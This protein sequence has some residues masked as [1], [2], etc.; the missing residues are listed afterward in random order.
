MTGPVRRFDAAELRGSDALPVSEAE[1]AAALGVARGLERAAADDIRPTF[2]FADRVMAAVTTEPAP[3]VIVRPADT[4]LGGR[5]GAFLV[6]V[7]DAWR[8]SISP[9][10]PTFVRAQAMA[11]VFLVVLAS[12]SLS[13]VAAIGA[14][15]FLSEDHDST[16]APTAPIGPSPQPMP[17]PSPTPSTSPGPSQSPNPSTE[18]AETPEPSDHAGGSARPT[19]SH[20]AGKTARPTATDDRTAKPTKTPHETETPEPTETPE[21]SDDHGGGHD[22]SSGDGDGPHPSDDQLGTR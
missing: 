1:M 5:L 21:G 6:S 14:A 4:V 17:A 18:P 20:D 16:P 15:G 10:R 8:V 22:G 7:R 2:G 3:R 13:A 11:F 12:G 9:G 19:E